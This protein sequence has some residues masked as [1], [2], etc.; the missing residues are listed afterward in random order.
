MN[1]FDFL[2]LQVSCYQS[3]VVSVGL[4]A[5]YHGLKFIALD[6]FYILDTDDVESSHSEDN[7]EILVEFA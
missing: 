7:N 1:Q 6:D 2:L 4:D 3:D 5:F